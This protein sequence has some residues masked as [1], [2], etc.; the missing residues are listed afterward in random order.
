MKIDRRPRFSI[1]SPISIIIK[2][3][4]YCKSINIARFH[5]NIYILKSADP[6]LP[7]VSADKFEQI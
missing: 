6:Y 2:L 1:N 3:E 5:V 7:M 4:K